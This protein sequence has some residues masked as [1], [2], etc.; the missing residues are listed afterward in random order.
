[1]VHTGLLF[2]SRLII[3]FFPC[4]CVLLQCRHFIQIH[5][6]CKS[7]QAINQSEKGIP[8]RIF[9]SQT[10]SN[11]WM[12]ALILIHSHFFRQRICIVFIILFRIENRRR[13]NIGA[14]KNK[15]IGYWI[16][17][18]ISPLKTANFPIQ[19]IYSR[20]CSSRNRLKVKQWALRAQYSTLWE[21][22]CVSFA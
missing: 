20:T 3:I 12:F 10:Y 6:W 16:F 1:M 8:A 18:H 11:V 17:R 9:S 14:I 13:G 21:M 22:V 7:Y 2:F 15:F 4:E 19:T 5:G